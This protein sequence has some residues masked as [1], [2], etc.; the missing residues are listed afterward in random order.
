MSTLRRIYQETQLRAQHREGM[1]HS[2]TQTTS[3]FNIEGCWLTC[4][5][6]GVRHVL[7]KSGVVG[8]TLVACPAVRFLRVQLFKLP[9]LLSQIS[10][11]ANLVLHRGKLSFLLFF[12]YAFSQ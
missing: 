8:A 11:D 12:I 9:V 4:K 7:G 1:F 2:Q 5:N 6:V 10:P 3:H